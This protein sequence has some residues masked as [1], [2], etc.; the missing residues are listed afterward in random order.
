MA[1]IA[2]STVLIWFAQKN[3]F[4]KLYKAECLEIAKHSAFYII[5]DKIIMD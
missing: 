2:G 5:H 4:M 1:H 3:N